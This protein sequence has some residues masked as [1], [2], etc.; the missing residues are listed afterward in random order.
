MSKTSIYALAL[1]AIVFSATMAE[2]RG[3]GG[4]SGSSMRGSSSAGGQQHTGNK[5]QVGFKPM[6]VLHC[7]KYGR[8]NGSGGVTMV[9][10]CN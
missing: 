1:G 3:G 5:Q 9:T 8:S 10:V 6:K 4:G 2:A 7:G